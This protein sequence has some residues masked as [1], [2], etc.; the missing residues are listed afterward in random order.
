MGLG[1]F[2]AGAELYVGI[3]AVTILVAATNAGVLGVSRLVYSM[4]L[5]RQM[6]DAMRRLHPRFRT[7]WLG[8]L[9]FAGFAC[10]ALAPGQAEFLGAIYAFGAMLS[11]SMAHLAVLR[12]RIAQPD[13]ARPYRSP[14]SVSIRGHELPPFALAGLAGTALSLAVVSALDLTVAATG[15]GWLAAR[16]RRLRRL[17]PAP[18]PRPRLDVQGG[19][20]RACGRARGRVRLSAG[21]RHRRRLDGRCCT[22]AKLAARKRRGIHVLVT[23]TVPNA[24]PPDA[25]MPKQRPRRIDHRAGQAAGRAARHRPLGEGAGGQAGRRI[26]EEAGTC[27]GGG[28][29][30]VPRRIAG[31]WVFGGTVE[32]V[33]RPRRA[34]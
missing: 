33:S 13:H 1:P 8:I 4:G 28:R 14:G 29:D 16:R 30:E 23:I 18:G 12:L 25:P 20:P 22:A 17:P 31:A 9:V 27:G 34:G 2:Q 3:L 7:P 10:V 32:T 11:F 5:H 15:S 6:P 24:R 26:I 21:P 19:D